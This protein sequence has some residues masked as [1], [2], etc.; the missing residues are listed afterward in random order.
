MSMSKEDLAIGVTKRMDSRTGA[1]VLTAD[2]EIIEFLLD[3]CEIE[4][5]SQNRFFVCVDCER[6]IH[7]VWWRR[8]K[9]WHSEIE[10]SELFDGAEAL[11]YTGACDFSHTNTEWQSVISLGIYGLRERIADYA[12]RSSENPSKVSFYQNLLKCYDAALRFMKRAADKA[13]ELGRGEM[14]DGLLHLCEGKPRNLFEALQVSIVYYTLMHHFEGTYLRTLGR[15]DKLFYPYYVKEEATAARGLLE[16]YMEEIDRLRAPS[17]IPFALSGTDE[18]GNDLTNELSYLWLDVYEKAKTSNTKLHVLCSKKTPED[19]IKKALRCVRDGNNSIVFM[20]DEQVITSLKKQGAEHADAVNYH[21]VGCYECGAEGE[22]TCSCNARVNVPKA[23][24]VALSGGVDMQTGRLIGLRPERA[25]ES[26]DDLVFEFERQLR[27]FSECAMKITNLYESHYSEIHSSPFLSGAYTSA[28][29]KGG[30]LYC[31]YTAKY[32][33]SSLNA[34]G[35]ATATDSL[36]A[37]KKL[38]YED[39]VMS[40]DELVETLKNDWKEKEPLRLLIKNKYPKYGQGNKSVDAIAKRIVDVLSDTVS[41][42]PNV[43]GGSWRLGLF[44][45]DWRWQFGEKTAAS[46]DGRHSAETVSQNTSASFGADKEGATAHLISGASID[47]T[48]TPNGAI[49]DIDLHSSA[50][51]GE[52]GIS[53]L[54]SSLRTYFALGGFAVQYNVMDTEILKD[55]KRNPEKYPTLQVRLCGWNVLFSSLS[56]KEKD[57]FIARSIK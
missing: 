43:K 39:G 8:A 55:A 2:S 16:S 35:L 46:A 6:L 25:T 19:I 37:I 11:A 9:P 28:L 1:D 45:I 29:E 10:K 22:L 44:S 38:V 36:A 24:E 21:V 49:L 13:A 26:F 40:L 54:L 34:I 33:S 18:Y 4:I 15:I 41:Y 5:P 47:T 50:V 51:R 27:Y 52:N 23:L 17:N 14:A 56:E 32:N 30:D 31:D 53:A 3:N 42:K 12:K 7:S 48:K 57:E 20:S